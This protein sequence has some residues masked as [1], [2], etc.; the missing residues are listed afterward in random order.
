MARAVHYH[1]FAFRGFAFRGSVVQSSVALPVRVVEVD[2]DLH[3][4]QSVYHH[5]IEL[6]LTFILPKSDIKVRDKI[7]EKR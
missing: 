7:K 3:K 4:G 1:N 6:Y 2:T 5:P